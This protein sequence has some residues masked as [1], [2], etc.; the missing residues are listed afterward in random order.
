MCSVDIR[1]VFRK[2]ACATD[3]SHLSYACTM[4]V[5]AVRYKRMNF[6]MCAL[7]DEGSLLCVSGS[8]GL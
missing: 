6:M 7:D 8:S 4:Y 5:Y 3:T 2:R 1:V